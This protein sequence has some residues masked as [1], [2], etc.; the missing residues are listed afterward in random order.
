MNISLE[1]TVNML[2]EKDKILV[3]T[4]KNPDGDA[5]G[6][7][8]ALFLALKKMGKNVIMDIGAK[9]PEVYKEICGAYDRQ[10]NFKPQFVVSVDLADTNLLLEH[11]S[12]FKDKIDLSIDHHVSNTNYSKYLLLDSKVASNTEL[13]YDVIVK[14]LGS[15]SIDSRI[16]S[17]LYLGIATDSGCFKYS[18]VTAKTHMVAAD[19]I[20]KGA[21]YYHINKKMFDTKSKAKIQIEQ[22]LLSNIEYYFDDRCALIFVSK[23]LKDQFEISDDELEGLSSLPTQIEGVDIGVTIKENK[24]KK[25]EH[26]I[27]I[28]TNEFYDASKICEKFGGGGHKRAG[29]CTIVGSNEEV[30]NKLINVISEFLKN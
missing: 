3:I 30:K 29:G 5:I 14:L 20:T 28:R 10:Y 7:S 16:S 4:H 13:L 12:F 15:R 26:K 22:I 11:L 24:D 27:S 21:D 1:E 17:C 6:S 19:L 9:I 2:K 18:S 8:F 25:F 23:E